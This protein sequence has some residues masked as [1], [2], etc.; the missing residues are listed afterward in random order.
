MRR[1]GG[2]SNTLPTRPISPVALAPK[3]ATSPVALRPVTPLTPLAVSPLAPAAQQ[4]Q[5]LNAPIVATAPPGLFDAAP[6]AEQPAYTSAPPPAYAIAPPPQWTPPPPPPK[7]TATVINPLTIGY[8]PVQRR[9]K[10]RRSGLPGLPMVIFIIVIAASIIGPIIAS[11]KSSLHTSST[12][13]FTV[14]TFSIPTFNA[15]TSG[16]HQQALHTSTNLDI[17]L[18]FLGTSENVYQTLNGHY[19]YSTAALAGS[20]FKPDPINRYSIGIGTRGYCAVGNDGPDTYWRLYKSTTEYLAGGNFRTE[21]EAKQA[22][23]LPVHWGLT[24]TIR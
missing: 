11:V 14:P 2:N 13:T 24:G 4:A 10:R 17:A 3:A 19:T 23:P 18:I 20:G 9:T 8:P 22:C 6:V 15:P 1:P 5:A 12:P 21:A 7:P 16:G